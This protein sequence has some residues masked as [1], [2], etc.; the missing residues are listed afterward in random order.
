MADTVQL[1]AGAVVIGVAGSASMDAWSAVLRR[2]FGIPTLDYRLLGRWIGHIAKGRLAHERI[3]A[4]A[5]IPAEA[6]LGWF[7]HYAIGVTFALV[8]VAIWGPGWLAA[9]TPG[10]ALVVGIG[11]ILAPWLVMQP[12]MGLGV[13]AARS[14]NPK[15]TRLRNLGTHA[16]YGVGLYLG[17]AVLAILR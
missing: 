13:A 10:P 8:L 16:V 17:A 7:A 2:R 1:V 4:A 6:A 15:A 12:A 11:T 9:P 14:P 3:G 5:P